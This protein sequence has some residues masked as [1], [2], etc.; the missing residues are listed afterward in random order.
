MPNHVKIAFSG[1]HSTGKTTAANGLADRLKDAGHVTALVSGNSRRC[2]NPIN[3]DTSALSQRMIFFGQALGETCAEMYAESIFGGPPSALYPTSE[4]IGGTVFRFPD[5]P[6]PLTPPGIS[7]CERTIMDNL[8]YLTTL[9][10]DYDGP[11]SVCREM[12]P[13]A[14][15][16]IGLRQLAERQLLPSY[17]MIFH[18]VIDESVEVEDD[19]V[20]DTDPV[21]RADIQRRLNAIWKDSLRRVKHPDKVMLSLEFR[22]CEDAVGRITDF[23]KGFRADMPVRPASALAS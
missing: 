3:R 2:L 18:T 23:L 17:S 14:S 21:Y 11:D 9:I 10:P 15:L 1:A 16:F 6:G 5:R 4:V 8:A 12:G 22:G 19:G 13:E 7:V 20:R